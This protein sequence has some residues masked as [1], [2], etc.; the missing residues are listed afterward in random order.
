LF[1][2]KIG[3]KSWSATY[4]GAQLEE[5]KGV[6]L[7]LKEGE[8]FRKNVYY[9][10]IICF[11]ENV[12]EYKHLWFENSLGKKMSVKNSKKSIQKLQQASAQGSQENLC[13]RVLL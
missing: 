7:L 10:D 8:Y 4:I 6:G 3:R 5:D 2:G 11:D 9:E 13:K 1:G 12:Y